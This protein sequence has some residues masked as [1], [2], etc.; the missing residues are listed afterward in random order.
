M[1]KYDC[2]GGFSEGR[3]GVQLGK[4]Y[5][6][7]DKSGKEVVPPKYDWTGHF[8]EGRA[9]VRLGKKYGFVDK[10]GKETRN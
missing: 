8:Y 4:K 9:R 1:K 2:V 10:S 3:A 7:I 5:G 6:F